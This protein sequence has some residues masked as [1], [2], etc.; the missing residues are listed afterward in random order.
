M[1]TNKHGM[2]KFGQRENIYVI[3]KPLLYA[4]NM[5]IIKLAP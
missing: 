3:F 5:Y 2:S 1:D 4:I